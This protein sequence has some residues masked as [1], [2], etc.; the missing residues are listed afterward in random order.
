MIGP[1]ELEWRQCNCG[2]MFPA[3]KNGAEKECLVCRRDSEE[4]PTSPAVLPTPPSR[5][6]RP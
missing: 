6:V 5:I 4:K 1:K 2:R 3:D